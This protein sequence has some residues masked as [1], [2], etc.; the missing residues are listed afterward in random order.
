MEV[1][2]QVVRA[3]LL[4]MVFGLLVAAFWCNWIKD[5]TLRLLVSILVTAF[6]GYRAWLATQG[7]AKFYIVGLIFKVIWMLVF[8]CLFLYTIILASGY[9]K[10]KR[11]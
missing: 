8:G 6:A 11:K 10:K 4:D 9:W 3:V 5:K 1:T 7:P 2:I